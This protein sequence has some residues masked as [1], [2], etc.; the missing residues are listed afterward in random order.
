M[1]EQ[2]RL[3]EAYSNGE[4]ALANRIL[5]GIREFLPA[6]I[7]EIQRNNEILTQLANELR[8][9]CTD[10][11]IDYEVKDHPV[12]MLNRIRKVVV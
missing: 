9:W 12:D 3:E 2:Q 7:N 6:D 10:L 4:K 5:R 11:G 1:T 8:A